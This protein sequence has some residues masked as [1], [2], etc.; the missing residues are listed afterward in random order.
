M[1][2]TK[3]MGL[4]RQARLPKIKPITLHS[5]ITVE[6]HRVITFSAIPNTLLLQI[7]GDDRNLKIADFVA[8]AI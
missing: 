6:L 8:H 5:R 3:K 1:A 2:I 4:S 7:L